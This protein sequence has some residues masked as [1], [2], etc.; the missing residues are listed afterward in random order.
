MRDAINPV[1]KLAAQV[2]SPHGCEVYEL[3][4]EM[5]R[6]HAS[7]SVDKIS[8][9]FYLLRT[10]KLPCYD[11]KMTSDD[12]WRH[13]FHL[14]P[15]ERKAEILFDF[16]YR[17]SDKQW[18]PT[19]A[20]MLDWPERDPSLH[21]MRSQSSRGLMGDVPGE[22]SFF[23]CNLWTI[24]HVVLD[25]TENSDEYEVSIGDRQF[26]FYQPYL[27]QKPIS[28]QGRPELTLAIAIA[29]FGH[30]HNWVVCEAIEGK[31]VGRDIGLVG[32][33]EVHVLKKVGVIRTDDCSELLV[34]REN[35]LPLLQK[36]DCLFI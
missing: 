32:V 36:M 3:V 30:A 19:W 27:S 2:D 18:F 14:L 9:L 29:D 26:S 4:R 34:G 7:Q 28:I 13:C 11:E 17:G 5:S 31:R 10:T 8:G 12:F 24:P 35:G 23:V 25:E 15:V 22:S 16:P 6:R 33:A 20:Q 21:Q 1:I